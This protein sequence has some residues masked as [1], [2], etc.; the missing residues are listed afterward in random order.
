MAKDR[1]NKK[2]AVNGEFDNVK[3]SPISFDYKNHLNKVSQ[4]SAKD[5]NMIN[6]KIGVNLTKEQLASI[7]NAIPSVDEVKAR[8]GT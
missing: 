8:Q 6:S 3:P 1:R 2:D 7:L 4:L 5:L